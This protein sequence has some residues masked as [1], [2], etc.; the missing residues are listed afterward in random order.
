LANQEKRGK[1]G[2]GIVSIK[3]RDGR[4]KLGN[5]RAIL[6]LRAKHCHTQVASLRKCREKESQRKERKRVF[7]GIVVICS[8][9]SK[10]KKRGRVKVWEREGGQV[11]AKQEGGENVRNVKRWGCGEL[12]EGK[13]P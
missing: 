6:S 7:P 1:L 10:N 12:F 5:P 2:T 4:G 8:F 13:G 3:G 11:L 9:P